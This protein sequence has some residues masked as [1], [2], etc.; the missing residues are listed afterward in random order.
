MSAPTQEQ[1]ELGV[2]I[3]LERHLMHPS[4]VL[5]GQLVDLVTRLT[6]QAAPERRPTRAEAEAAY[7]EAI[8]AIRGVRHLGDHERAG[9]EAV[10]ALSGGFAPEP[11]RVPR[12]TVGSIGEGGRFV[13]ILAEEGG[14]TRALTGAEGLASVARSNAWGRFVQAIEAE[15]GRLGAAGPDAR[16]QSLVK[17]EAL[18]RELRAPEFGVGPEVSS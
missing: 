14:T 6:A 16:R 4:F 2:H 1:I 13:C 17:L 15:V 3:I 7:L 9:I 12:V 5:R 10:V 18:L 11:V 8:G